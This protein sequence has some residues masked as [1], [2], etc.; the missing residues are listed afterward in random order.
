MRMECPFGIL[1]LAVP[2]RRTLTM[3]H[4]AWTRES[5]L[6]CPPILK[7]CAFCRPD[8]AL[9]RLSQG[10]LGRR[11]FQGAVRSIATMAASS[12]R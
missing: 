11:A 12:P 6:G 3:C 8:N 5:R 1:G 9:G 7:P 10:P 4:A 2:S